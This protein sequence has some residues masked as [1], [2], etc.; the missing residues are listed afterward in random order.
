MRKGVLA[1][2][3]V[4]E[5]FVALADATRRSQ[6]MPEA[7]MIVLPRSELVEY[8]GDEAKEAAAQ[9]TLQ[10]LLENSSV[11]E[12][13]DHLQLL[14]RRHAPESL[15]LD[16]MEWLVHGGDYAATEVTGR[17]SVDH[18]VGADARIYCAASNSTLPVS[19]THFDASRI[20]RETRCPCAS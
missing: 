17:R 2:L 6:G 16:G 15:D 20:S 3:L 1:V 4:T 13:G 12:V 10:A 19:V 18:L 9:S 14:R 11:V 8:S 7:P 5:R